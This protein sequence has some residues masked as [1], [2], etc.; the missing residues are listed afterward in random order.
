MVAQAV[1]AVLECMEF[2]FCRFSLERIDI[3][4]CGF[5]FKYLG[6]ND[7]ARPASAPCL[8]PEMQKDLIPR[9][10][11]H[12]GTKAAVLSELFHA[13]I[14]LHEH[15]L[16]HLICFGGIAEMPPHQDANIGLVAAQHCFE[17]FAGIFP[18]LFGEFCFNRVAVRCQIRGIPIPVFEVMDVTVYSL[19]GSKECH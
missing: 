13:L 18:S 15:L 10:C 12:P 3:R 7:H 5:D 19:L 17:G 8:V 9:N 1:Q 11:H 14:D 6:W 4:R 16:S 2:C